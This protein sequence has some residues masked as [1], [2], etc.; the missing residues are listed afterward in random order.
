MK[1]LKDILN[2]ILTATLAI[3]LFFGLG[4]TVKRM[5][6]GK[7]VEPFLGW[8]NAIVISG[9]MS[10]SVEVDDMVIIREKDTYREGDIITFERDGVFLTHRI[11]R[12]T[13]EGFITK[14]DA[15]N[16]EDSA[17]VAEEDIVGKVVFVIPQVG[18]VVS[19][20]RIPVVAG[21]IAAGCCGLVMYPV[22]SAVVK[23][24]KEDEA[25]KREQCDGA[26]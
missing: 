17:P 19:F 7:A 9:S 22:I 6:S 16:T 5:Q 20:A 12:V 8:A 13:P 2:V 15:N 10:G 26:E 11:V 4:G 3:V 25:D 14:G 18:R 1:R 24:G 23:K 21:L